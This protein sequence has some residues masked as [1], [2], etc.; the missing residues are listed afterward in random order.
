MNEVS[1]RRL[2]N[3]E[4]SKLVSYSTLDM[5]ITDP[6]TMVTGDVNGAVIQWIR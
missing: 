2:L 1:K 5:T 4:E 3:K 6:A